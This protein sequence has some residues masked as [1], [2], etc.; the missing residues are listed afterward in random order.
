MKM[1]NTVIKLLFDA[2]NQPGFFENATGITGY[3]I[4][5]NVRILTDEVKDYQKI[6][7]DAIKKYGKESSEGYYTIDQ[8]DTKAVEKFT[9]EILPIANAE[10]DVDLFQISEDQFDLPFCETATPSQYAIIEE[11]LIKHTDSEDDITIQG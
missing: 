2:L 6:I 10:I 3:A 1:T 8:T 11:F 5:K 4:Y 9:K 7:D